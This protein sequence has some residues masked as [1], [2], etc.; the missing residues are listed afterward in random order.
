MY[1]ASRPDVAAELVILL[2]QHNECTLCKKISDDSSLFFAKTCSGLKNAVVMHN[3]ITPLGIDQ[4]LLQNEIEG[5]PLA[6]LTRTLSFYSEQ[7]V[8]D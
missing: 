5:L 6:N 1:V 8:N 4:E 7:R 3:L 2:A